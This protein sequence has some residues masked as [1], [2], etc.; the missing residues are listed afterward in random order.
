MAA[1]PQ[2]EKRAHCRI[3]SAAVR[4]QTQRL[5]VA[6]Q[7]SSG[8]IEE[9]TEAVVE[10]EVEVAGDKRRATGS[11]SIYLSDLWAWPDSTLD[12]PER[13]EVLR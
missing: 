4:F 2:V 13:D 11:G 8:T 9:V 10:V 7:L 12:H 3:C 6:L 1:P 5:A